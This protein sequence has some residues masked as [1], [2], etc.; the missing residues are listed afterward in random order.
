MS[1][2]YGEGL[3]A[4][5]YKLVPSGLNDVRKPSRKCTYPLLQVHFHSFMNGD[6]RCIIYP[7][8]LVQDVLKVDVEEYRVVID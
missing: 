4:S 6:P 7:R 2:Y 8:F 5:V 1:L 3:S